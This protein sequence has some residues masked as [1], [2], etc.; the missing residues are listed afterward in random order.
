MSE[1]RRPTRS[2]ASSSAWSSPR[3]LGTATFLVMVQ[4]SFHK[5]YTDL[6]FNHTLGTAVKGTTLRE[7]EARAA[8]GIVATR[9]GPVGLYA[10]LIG[11]AVLLAIYGLVIRRLHRHWVLTGLGLG[12]GH[13]LVIGLGYAP[14]ADA[15]QDEAPW[16]SSAS[17]RGA[18]RRWCWDSRRWGSGWSPPAASTSSRAPAGGAARAGALTR[19]RR[20]PGWTSGSLELPEEGPEKGG[21]RA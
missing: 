18:S 14:I 16:G 17:T 20:S 19:W 15:R 3:P 5:G 8:V 1:R 13:F 11:A 21:V 9:P 2:A 12:R 4:G 6:D 7:T 10:G